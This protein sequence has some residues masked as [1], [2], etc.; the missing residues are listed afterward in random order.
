MA[1]EELL[2]DDDD[3]EDEALEETLPGQSTRP[4]PT[5]AAAT[6]RRRTAR[7]AACRSPTAPRA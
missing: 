3:D 5:A 7:P 6:V 4:R 1:L 2:P